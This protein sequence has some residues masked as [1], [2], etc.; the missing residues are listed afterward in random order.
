MDSE[1]QTITVS[2]TTVFKYIDYFGTPYF[3]AMD[4]FSFVENDNYHKQV[5]DILRAG[6]DYF[7]MRIKGVNPYFITPDGIVQLVEHMSRMNF[8]H[9]CTLFRFFQENY[10]TDCTIPEKT[11][12]HCVICGAEIPYNAAY[13]QIYCSKKCKNI[14]VRQK[15][16]EKERFDQIRRETTKCCAQCGKEFATTN[17]R[18]IFCSNVCSLLYRR[19]HRVSNFSLEEKVCPICGEK[20]IPIIH[21]QVTC[22]LPCRKKMQELKRQNKRFCKQCGAIF[23]ATAKEKEFCSRDCKVAYY[24]KRNFYNVKEAYP[25]EYRYYTQKIV[26][27]MRDFLEEWP[28]KEE[29]RKPDYQRKNS[30][31]VSFD[32]YPV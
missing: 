5:K 1:I 32:P 11:S 25:D 20:F 15:A 7:Q 16:R 19:E 30:I 27:N 31:L 29:L 8:E 22:S 3:N 28:S 26:P 23:Q 9:V 2:D 10:N 21:S 12:R 17:P 13:Q 18:Q 14:A 24:Q 6:V 4:V